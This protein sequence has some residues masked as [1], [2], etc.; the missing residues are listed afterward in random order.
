MVLLIGGNEKKE[1]ERERRK[2][3]TCS[4]VEKIDITRFFISFGERWH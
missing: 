4:L 3:W 2:M 1:N